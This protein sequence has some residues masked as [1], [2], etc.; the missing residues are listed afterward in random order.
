MTASACSSWGLSRL[1]NPG[2]CC[3]GRLQAQAPEQDAVQ[4]V[5]EEHVADAVEEEL[6]KEKAAQPQKDVRADSLE[7]RVAGCRT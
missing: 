2:G 1:D 6:P 7:K 3:R 4:D 5:E